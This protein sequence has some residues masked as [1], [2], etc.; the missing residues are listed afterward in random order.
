[1]LRSFDERLS[2]RGI[3]Q[4]ISKAFDRVWHEAFIFKLRQNGIYWDMVNISKDFLSNRKQ[5]A[6]LNGQCSSWADILF[7]APQCS[8]VWPF[9]SNIH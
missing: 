2:V 9:V 6:V 1:M 7:G 4:D 8:I 5:R 3:F